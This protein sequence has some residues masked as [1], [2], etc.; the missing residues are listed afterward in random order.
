MIESLRDDR[1]VHPIRAFTKIPGPI[2]ERGSASSAASVLLPLSSSCAIGAC[3][4]CGLLSLSRLTATTLAR[5]QLNTEEK[6][7]HNAD[8]Y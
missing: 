2:S 4:C 1:D 8:N 3:G 5:H 7:C 6:D